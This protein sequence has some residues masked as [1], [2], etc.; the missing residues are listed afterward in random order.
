MNANLSI[1]LEPGSNVQVID[2]LHKPP[3][4]AG[5]CWVS[6]TIDH[7]CSVMIHATRPQQLVEIGEL[8]AEAGE[9]LAARLAARSVPQVA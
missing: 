2:G 8:I 3:V 5:H 9:S 7:E 4:D 1:K 6:L